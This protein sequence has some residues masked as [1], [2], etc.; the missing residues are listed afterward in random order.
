MC[1]KLHETINGSFFF[2]LWIVTCMTYSLSKLQCIMSV[3]GGG[4]LHACLQWAGGVVCMCVSGGGGVP[5][6]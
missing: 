5:L 3:G 1:E 4:A 2:T 6:Y